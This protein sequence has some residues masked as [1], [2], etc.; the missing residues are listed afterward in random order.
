MCN[1]SSQL[2]RP[3][4]VRSGWGRFWRHTA[5]RIVVYQIIPQKVSFYDKNC[6]KCHKLHISSGDVSIARELLNQ[7]EW[8][9]VRCEHVTLP[10]HTTFS[11]LPL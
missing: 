1:N 9:N 8:E 5:R 4:I 11:K 3:I 6:Q 7:N 10:S 2:L